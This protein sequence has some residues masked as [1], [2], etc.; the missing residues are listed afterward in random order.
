MKV[1]RKVF[2]KV[3]M[4]KKNQ[5]V[6]ANVL[7]KCQSLNKQKSLTKWPEVVTQWPEVVKFVFERVTSETSF[8]SLW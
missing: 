6:N 2:N 3:Q 8:P 4:M 1:S 7:C 5:N